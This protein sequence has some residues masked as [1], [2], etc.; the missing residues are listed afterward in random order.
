MSSVLLTGRKRCSWERYS[1]N[2]FGMVTRLLVGQVRNNGSVLNRET[3]LSLSLSPKYLT[4][5]AD[6]RNSF[7]KVELGHSQ[8][9]SENIYGL[10]AHLY[11][12][13]T[14]CR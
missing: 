5:P 7:S 2:S 6:Y 9:S 12:K 4:S 14:R 13:L 3:P 1:N 11:V 10:L 8:S